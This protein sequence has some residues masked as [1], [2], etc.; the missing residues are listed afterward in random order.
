M[1]TMGWRI[2]VPS[3]C[4]SVVGQVDVGP[5]GRMASLRLR[6]Q[7]RPP[8]WP[9][10][11][12]VKAASV[13]HHLATNNEHRK[14]SP[15]H[16]IQRIPNPSPS[17]KECLQHRLHDNEPRD[18]LITAARACCTA[19]GPSRPLA[20][21]T[22]AVSWSTSERLLD[23]WSLIPRDCLRSFP[24]Y[25]ALPRCPARRRPDRPPREMIEH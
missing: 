20:S 2:V 4:H 21:R 7:T 3:Q 10:L 1:R 25:T 5:R 19:A 6:R 17:Y 14:S 12:K 16:A 23:V 24:L 9:R 15:P 8:L 18:S 22:L 13:H 11:V